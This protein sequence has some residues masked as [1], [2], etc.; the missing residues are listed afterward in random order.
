MSCDNRLPSFLP[1][2]WSARKSVHNIN[3]SRVLVFRIYFGLLQIRHFF[4]NSNSLNG[5]LTL[6]LTGSDWEL[7][8]SKEPDSFSFLI[9]SRVFFMVKMDRCYHM[10]GTVSDSTSSSILKIGSKFLMHAALIKVF[11]E[12]K[13]SSLLKFS[14]LLLE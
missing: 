2:V 3:F 9:R 6:L 12:G 1:N 8:H 5:F 13:E 11:H 7:V 4:G 10:S 14:T